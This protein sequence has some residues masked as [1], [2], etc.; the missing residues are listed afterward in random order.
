MW[1]MGCPR[2]LMPQYPRISESDIRSKKINKFIIS[3]IRMGVNIIQT[4]ILLKLF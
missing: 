3:D 1:R 2:P 4:L